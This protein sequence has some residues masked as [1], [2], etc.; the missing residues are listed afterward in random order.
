MIIIVVGVLV[1][2]KRPSNVSFIRHVCELRDREGRLY[3]V[4]RDAPGDCRG[5]RAQCFA[6]ELLI[7]SHVSQVD[8][9]LLLLCYVFILTLQRKLGPTD[10]H[11]LP[12]LLLMLLRADCFIHE[13]YLSTTDHIWDFWLE[14]H[15]AGV[16]VISSAAR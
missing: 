2:E 7:G 4:W 13:G 6:F 11:I 10:H 3:F 9:V 15:V 8:I 12:I 16:G 14:L 1:A 5:L